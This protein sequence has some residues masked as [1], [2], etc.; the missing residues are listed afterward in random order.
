MPT[1]PR[2]LAEHLADAYSF[3]VVADTEGGFVI[4]FPDLPGC[5]TQVETL[6]EV[7]AAADEVRQLWIETEY[8]RGAE[9]PPPSAPPE[10]SG[11]FNVRIPKSLH[12]RLA[13]QAAHEGVSL[14]QYVTALLDRGDALARV[15]CRLAELEQRL[16]AAHD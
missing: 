12:A 1:S 6:A 13:E 10:Y 11:R 8:G 3:N 9:V 4:V 5:M 14:N 16:D 2:P 15:E 7:P